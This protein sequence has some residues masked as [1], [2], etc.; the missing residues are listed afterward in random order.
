[1]GLNTAPSFQLT[2]LSVSD[3]GAF[4]TSVSG[5]VAVAAVKVE[6]LVSVWNF[7][8]RTP[9]LTSHASDSFRVSNA[10]TAA[11]NVLPFEYAP[12]NGG[13]RNTSSMLGLY[14][15]AAVAA[16]RPAAWCW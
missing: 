8:Q 15:L 5:V 1:M 11:L 4:C 12:L 14:R 10:Y 6:L 16:A 3:S 13:S 2:R 9:A 7:S